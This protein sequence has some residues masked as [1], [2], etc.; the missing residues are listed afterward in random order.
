LRY[1]KNHNHCFKC[2]DLG[3]QPSVSKRSVSLDIPMAVSYITDDV[4]MIRPGRPIFAEAFLNGTLQLDL[5]LL[6]KFVIQ[7]G[8]SNR[9]CDGS[10]SD[11]GEEVYECW[12]DFGCAGSGSMEI[13]LGVWRP[14]QICGIDVLDK[15]TA[16]EQIQIKA[17]LASVYDC[18]Q[19][20]SDK[21]QESIGQFPLFNY[22]PRDNI[23]FHN[24]QLP[25]CRG[26]E[27]RMEHR[28]SQVS[29]LF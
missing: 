5:P 10:V 8:A 12:V 19:V 18:I 28:P 2:N 1:L 14:D 24:T 27:E 23:R 11:A 20:S 9:V 4:T 25:R 7:H 6:L 26:H 22:Q 16:E 29:L 21:I 3:I 13:A 17:C 15:C